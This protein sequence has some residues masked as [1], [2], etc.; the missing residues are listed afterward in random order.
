MGKQAMPQLNVPEAI[1]GLHPAIWGDFKNVTGNVSKIFGCITGLRGNADGLEGDVT[2]ITGDFSNITGKVS[3][4]HK[5]DVSKFIGDVTG[6]T[7][8]KCLVC[9]EHSLIVFRNKKG[10][11]CNV[12]YPKVCTDCTEELTEKEKTLL[13]MYGDPR[14]KNNHNGLKSSRLCLKCY[15]VNLQKIKEE[16]VRR[17]TAF[18]DFQ[19]EHQVCKCG[20]LNDSRHQDGTL[21]SRYCLECRRNFGEKIAVE[22]I[23]TKASLPKNFRTDHRTI[24]FSSV[25]GFRER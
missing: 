13:P 22:N 14:L 23:L 12:C 21:S 18:Y 1:V 8:R 17:T 11:F 24:V 10:S 16:E 2:E 7:F 3:P 19:L 5:G 6:L 9:R 25:E 15:L 4:K 20:K